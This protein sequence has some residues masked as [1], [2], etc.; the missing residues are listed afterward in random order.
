VTGSILLLTDSTPEALHT[1]REHLQ[2]RDYTLTITHDMQSALQMARKNP[3]DALIVD[4]A[5][6][7]RDDLALCQWL[8]TDPT[9]VAVRLLVAAASPHT[10]RAAIAAGADEVLVR[11]LDAEEI[12]IRLRTMQTG[13]TRLPDLETFLTHT[14]DLI[15][16]ANPMD[17]L[18][19]A[20]LLSHDLKS[21]IGIVISS[22]ELLCDFASERVAQQ[23]PDAEQELHL[24]ENALLAARRQIRL[25][26]DMIDLA[27]IEV[28]AYPIHPQPL[29][30]PTILHNVI[31]SQATAINRR[32]VQITLIAPPDDFPQA[33]GDLALV[34]R[35]SHAL[36]E[37]ILKFTRSGDVA[38]V[39]FSATPDHIQVGFS[40]SGRP[41][42][43]AHDRAIFDR[44]IQWEARQQGGRSSVAMGLPF[45]RAAARHMNGDLRAHSSAADKRT[46]F[47][48]ELPRSAPV[49]AK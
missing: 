48:L 3:P 30:L 33:L 24:T 46:T 11:P 36:L 9:T 7:T 19:S 21:P 25:I 41:I 5:F 2:H 40:D 28:N 10:R 35:I 6:E 12:D 18:G 26:N 43:P 39:H 8:R 47:C 45:A 17:I 4:M 31:T 20:D 23:L 49:L 15:L 13:R 29:A 42:L 44:S 16:G 32:G 27:K 37:N 38:E 22:L 34:Q 1:L 14:P